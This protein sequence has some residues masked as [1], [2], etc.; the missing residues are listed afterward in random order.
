M[1]QAVNARRALQE[2]D[3]VENILLLIAEGILLRERD[4][5][6]GV[7]E[8]IEKTA[9]VNDNI[10]LRLGRSLVLILSCKLNDISGTVSPYYDSVQ[11]CR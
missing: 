3:E 4:S 6:R 9:K 11:S 7:S 5:S 8:P 2:E 1:T 10:S